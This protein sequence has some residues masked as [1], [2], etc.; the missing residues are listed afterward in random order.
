MNLKIIEEK[1]ERITY[2]KVIDVDLNDENKYTELKT[3]DNYEDA[4]NFALN[5]LGETPCGEE[6]P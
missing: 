3:F 4:N 2:F 6:K 5:L 1:N